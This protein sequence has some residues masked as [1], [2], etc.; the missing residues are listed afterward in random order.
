MLV[1]CSFPENIA[2]PVAE[3]HQET[4]RLTFLPT[5]WNALLGAL[6]AGVVAA[7][8]FYNQVLSNTQ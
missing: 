4:R 1:A 3:P 7:A 6:W 8:A 5:P 2:F